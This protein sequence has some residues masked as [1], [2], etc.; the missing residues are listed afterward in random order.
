MEGALASIDIDELVHT[1]PTALA[2]KFLRRF[3]QPIFL[4]ADLQPGVPHRVKMLDEHFTLFRCVSGAAALLEDRCKHRQTQLS[5]G[6][7]EGDAIR[8]F[9]HGWVWDKR[10]NCIEQPAERENFAP[11]CVRSYP[12]REYLGFIFAY[13]GTGETPEFPRF[14][15]VEREGWVSASRVDP[16]PC[17]YFQRLENDVDEVHVPFVHKVSSD[18][19]G[20]SLVPKVRAFESEY[21]MRR[22][23][24]RADNSVRVAH[25]LMPNILWTVIPPSAGHL[26]W[27]VPVDDEHTLSFIVHTRQADDE[28]ARKEARIDGR[29]TA[30]DP[31]TLT[32]AILAGKMRVQDL[33]PAYPGL[34]HVQ[35]NVV[36]AGQGIITQRRL[37]RLAASD[38]AIAL[39]RRIWLRELTALAE[40]RPP[41]EWQ[42][43]AEMLQAGIVAPD[44]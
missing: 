17:N 42:R 15:E 9:Y 36:L 43:P 30:A 39:L 26:A 20:F 31:M 23:S 22:E 6:W 2:G 25:F 3:W 44:A 19:K 21:G 24:T 38:T 41:K 1:G 40:D 18:A 29:E 4:A 35:D 37:D 14:P 28:R 33:D 7:V 11:V 32:A 5:L 13:L 10:G 16:V 27:R 8:C 34:L 12:V